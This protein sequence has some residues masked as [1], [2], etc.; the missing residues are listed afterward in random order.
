MVAE[1]VIVSDS[2]R[3]N[4]LLFYQSSDDLESGEFL[5]DAIINQSHEKN[6]QHNIW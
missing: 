4:C 6:D 1:N 2:Y 3:D 5:N